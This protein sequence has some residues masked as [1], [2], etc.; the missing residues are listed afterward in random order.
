MLKYTSFF[1]HVP[2]NVT[3][4]NLCLVSQKDLDKASSY[5][6]PSFAS[7]RQYDYK[8]VYYLIGV[9]AKESM[10]R[11]YTMLS[12]YQASVICCNVTVTSTSVKE[13]V[14]HMS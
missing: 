2:T 10:G 4:S 14:R 3:V 7:S 5:F 1:G 9:E 8:D 13:C 11:I 12:T 6:F